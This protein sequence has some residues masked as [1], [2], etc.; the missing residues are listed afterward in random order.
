MRLAISILALQAASFTA[1]AS[2]AAVVEPPEALAPPSVELPIF[3][4]TSAIARP[5]S[6]ATMARM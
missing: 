1:G 4:S 5:S 3:S 2:D 6:S